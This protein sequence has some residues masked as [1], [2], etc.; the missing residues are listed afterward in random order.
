[1][2]EPVQVHGGRWAFI[3]MSAIE[4]QHNTGRVAERMKV[5]VPR[6]PLWRHRTGSG[7]TR[8]QDCGRDTVSFWESF[9]C[10]AERRKSTGAK[11][12]KT[13]TPII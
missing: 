9:R 1:M 7:T 12:E 4:E 8:P 3:D 10:H 2:A 13:Q 6:S 11:G 5:R